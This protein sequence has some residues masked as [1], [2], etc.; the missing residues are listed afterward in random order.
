MLVA[1]EEA[2][3]YLS[4]DLECLWR[5]Q[6]SVGRNVVVEISPSTIFHYNA[7]G[8]G[9]VDNLIE[10]HY[11]WVVQN[12]HDSEFPFN[13]GKISGLHLGL[14]HDL[15]GHFFAC[16]SMF[17]EFNLSISAF[18]YCFQHY[19]VAYCFLSFFKW[20]CCWWWVEA[21]NKLTTGLI[22]GGGLIEKTIS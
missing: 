16:G 5:R 12:G 18:S 17:S 20:F 22:P 3:H 15:D 7:S 4:E 11:V 21:N 2:C 1:I 19:I 6:S 13:P 10:P 14:L 8:V 9:C